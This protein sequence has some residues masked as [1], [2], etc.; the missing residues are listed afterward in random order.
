M[1]RRGIVGQRSFDRHQQHLARSRGVGGG[2]RLDGRQRTDQLYEPVQDL[3]TGGTSTTEYVAGGRQIILKPHIWRRF[4]S[5]SLRRIGPFHCG[6]DRRLKVL[7]G[8]ASGK[9]TAAKRFQAASP[10]K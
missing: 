1:A 4:Q 8:L 2:R 7:Y 6:H 9:A 5:S 3:L 10:V